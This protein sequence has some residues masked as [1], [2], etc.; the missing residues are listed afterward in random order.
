MKCYSI[1][2]FIKYY[3]TG[4]NDSVGICVTQVQRMHNLS[5]KKKFKTNQYI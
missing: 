4:K 5:H 3:Y 1:Y 2:Y